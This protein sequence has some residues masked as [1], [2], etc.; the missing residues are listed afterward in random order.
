MRRQDCSTLFLFD[1]FSFAPWYPPYDTVTGEPGNKSNAE[2]AKRNRRGY[3]C[4]VKTGRAY[5]A[6][7][8]RNR[9]VFPLTSLSHNTV[10]A[11]SAEGNE[12]KASKTGIQLSGRDQRRKHG[13]SP[14]FVCW[15]SPF[16][17]K[18]D[19]GPGRRWRPERG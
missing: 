12:M 5:L 14:C 3:E 7:R 1:V 2:G 11:S 16:L 13:C 9:I 17:R 18:R 10:K 19:S 4:T 6:G 15:S 8:T